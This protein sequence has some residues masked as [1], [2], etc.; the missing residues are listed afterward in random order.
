MLN[1]TPECYGVTVIESKLGVVR[2]FSRPS[3]R[4][5]HLNFYCDDNCVKTSIHFN[6][7]GVR[8][9]KPWEV[10]VYQSGILYRSRRYTD[11][12]SALRFAYF[13]SVR[14]L[15]AIKDMSCYRFN[16]GDQ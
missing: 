9:G 3:D 11:L 14:G 8:N 5:P 13:V 16:R 10:T 4:A 2:A 15:R 7:W 1:A 12:Y 6:Y